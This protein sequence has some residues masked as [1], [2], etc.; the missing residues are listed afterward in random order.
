MN[1]IFI[2][3]VIIGSLLA[4]AIGCGGKTT[5]TSPTTAQ[6]KPIDPSGN[7]RMEFTDSN[8]QTFLLSALFNQ[9]GASVS[10]VNIS[11]VGNNVP[12]FVCTVQPDAT[13]TN[14]LVQNVNQFTGDFNGNFGVIAFTSTLNDAGSH[15]SGT[16]TVTPGAEGACMG[17]N[18]TGSFTA[19]EVPSMTGNWTG[20][21]S[22]SSNCPTG[23]VSG[24]ITM[25]LTQNDA[26]GAVTGTYSITG[27]P[28]VSSGQI[29]PDIDNLLSGSSIQLRLADANGI[30]YFLVGGP[31][32]SFGT[33]G[34]NLDGTFQGDIVFG[35][36]G[37]PI[38]LITM[39]H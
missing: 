4:L 31:L 13:M 16:Y 19:D 35:T 26:T 2:Y 27:V 25:A 18:L 36:T 5:V 6:S 17:I 28:G 30:V 34:V 20:T 29:A 21:V 9:V 8:G 12:P 23:F 10:A 22:C 24:T 32:N 7:W 15:A 39:S 3:V 14:G 11:E 38:Y 1:R 33:S 37:D